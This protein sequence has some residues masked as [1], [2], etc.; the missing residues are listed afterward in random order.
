[1]NHD[2]I[3]VIVTIIASAGGLAMFIHKA[4]VDLR[5]HMAKLEGLFEGFTRGRSKQQE[6]A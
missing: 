2:T 1:M 5:E 3:I 6:A 4:I